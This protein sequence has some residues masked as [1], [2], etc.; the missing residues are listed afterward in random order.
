MTRESLIA[1]VTLA[2]VV[3]GIIGFAV[4][5]AQPPQQTG[6]PSDEKVA[7]IGDAVALK[8]RL[9][10]AQGDKAR[11]EA[12]PPKQ[13]AENIG[14]IEFLTKQLDQLNR[15]LDAFTRRCKMLVSQ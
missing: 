14:D 10:M 8:N 12:M 13:R 1:S 7:C 9:Q 15:D 11:F 6:V 2:A 3:V 4:L 5:R